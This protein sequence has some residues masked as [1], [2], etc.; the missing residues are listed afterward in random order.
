M[1][2]GYKQLETNKMKYESGQVWRYKARKSEKDT[3]VLILKTERIDSIDII[4]ITVFGNNYDSPEH[5]PFVKEAIDES[6][7]EL[8]SKSTT[9]PNYED[10]YNIWKEL[11][12]AGEAGIYSTS[13]ADTLSL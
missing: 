4:H 2:Y 6:V 8:E 5:M 9:V 11:Y 3:R 10:G 1:P 7:I 13:V 12:I